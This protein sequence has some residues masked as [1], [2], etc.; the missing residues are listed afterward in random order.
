VSLVNDSGLI[1]G[2][3]WTDVLII[4]V[5]IGIGVWGWR[6]GIIRA[7]VALLAVVVGV[8][9]AG[10]YHERVF[11][12]LAIA[13]APSGA[14]RAASFV[15]IMSLVSV[16][17]YVVG[18]FLRGMAS[19]L[20][21]GW[22][23]RAAGALFGVLFG[24]LLAQAVIAIVVLAGLDDA[25]GEIGDSVLGWAMMD[26]A[27]IVRALLPAEFDVA[28]QEFVA[29]VDTLRATVDGVQGPIGGG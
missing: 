10:V 20:L 22:A 12:D 7:G 9:L 8:V 4:V 28:I 16:G 15:V 5:A 13:E 3:S 14:M 2:L 21:L 17:G 23:D 29:E 27:P 6:L 18:T 26:N 24:L 1:L 25:T 19:V 11:V